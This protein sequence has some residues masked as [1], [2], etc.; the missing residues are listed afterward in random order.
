MSTTGDETPASV[1]VRPPSNY[2]VIVFCIFPFWGGWSITI[3]NI[4]FL[5]FPLVSFLLWEGCAKRDFD[6]PDIVPE[7]TEG[8][9]A[10][11]CKVLS[12][13]WTFEIHLH[14][15]ISALLEKNH[16]L[17]EQLTITS[18]KETY[19]KATFTKLL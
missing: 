19:P 6:V 15:C 12:M 11:W 9:V 7:E 17:K 1:L 3:G 18:K 5:K 4:F 8:F 10:T 13:L 14:I 2:K 16:I